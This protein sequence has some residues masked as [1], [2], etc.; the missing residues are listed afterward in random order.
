[1]SRLLESDV[2]ESVELSYRD[3]DIKKLVSATLQIRPFD[4]K[5]MIYIAFTQS[6][7]LASTIQ[8][9]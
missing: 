4:S 7:R 9:I 5:V 8:G 6:C 1:M 2:K 3:L